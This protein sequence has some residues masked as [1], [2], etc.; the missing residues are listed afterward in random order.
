MPN[1]YIVLLHKIYVK[2]P[3]N[4][5]FQL[6]FVT[7]RLSHSWGQG[8]YPIRICE[9]INSQPAKRNQ[10]IYF[11]SFI[12]FFYSTLYWRNFFFFWPW[13]SAFMGFPFLIILE[14]SFL[15]SELD[16]LLPG[17]QLPILVYSLVFM[18]PLSHFLSRK[19]CMGG[20]FSRWEWDGGFHN[21][22]S[23]AEKPMDKLL[24][25]YYARKAKTQA[26]S[27]E[28]SEATYLHITRF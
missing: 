21:I 20:S 26:G 25:I 27:R 5:S 12:T 1:L 15:S 23:G 19:G 13:A 3:Y 4:H 7:T 8:Q 16:P 24:L 22:I 9:N 14:I 18:K 28:N 2:V 11:F 6:C 17:I 10:I